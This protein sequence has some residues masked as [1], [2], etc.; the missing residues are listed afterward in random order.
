MHETYAVPSCHLGSCW[1]DDKMSISSLFFVGSTIML[2]SMLLG[3]LVDSIRDA[4]RLRFHEEELLPEEDELLPPYEYPPPAYVAELDAEAPAY[5]PA[6]Q[7]ELDVNEVLE[8]RSLE[9]TKL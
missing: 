6:Y 9:S 4:R 8:S 2:C 3:M 5:H 1:L 7:V